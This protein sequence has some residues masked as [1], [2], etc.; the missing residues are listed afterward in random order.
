MDIAKIMELI[1]SHGWIGL[2]L[3]IFIFSLFV[4]TIVNVHTTLLYK[5]FVIFNPERKLLRKTKSLRRVSNNN[6]TSEDVRALAKNEETRVLN[7]FYLKCN[8][9]VDVQNVWAK[10]IIF[11][12]NKNIPIGTYKRVYSLFSVKDSRL[13]KEIG[14]LKL[15]NT[16]IM[17][18]FQAILFL[19]SSGFGALSL[20]AS[21]GILG[22]ERKIE[23]TLLFFPYFIFFMAFFAFFSLETPNYFIYRKVKALIEEYNQTQ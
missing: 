4:L 1:I 23:L 3:F 10:L 14:L 5:V 18:I 20:A 22:S 15:V 11:H 21:L 7:S 6:K 16:W 9:S 12:K 2:L 19:L 17:T 13:E 8:L